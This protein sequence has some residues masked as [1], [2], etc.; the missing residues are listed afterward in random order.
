[1]RNIMK[2]KESKG[3]CL[4]TLSPS[5]SFNSV[6][7]FNLWSAAEILVDFDIWVVGRRSLNLTMMDKDT[8]GAL[9]V[10]T[11]RGTTT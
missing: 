1:M 6:A 5:F 2:D 9:L 8:L 3:R 4:A 10:A 7:T 11:I